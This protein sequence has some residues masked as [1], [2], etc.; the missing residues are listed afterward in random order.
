MLL[1][2]CFCSSDLTP[3]GVI[4]R[5]TETKKKPKKKTRNGKMRRSTANSIEKKREKTTTKSP[6]QIFS[7]TTRNVDR[8]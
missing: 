8:R 3:P 7:E 4:P 1:F 5:E 2:E 6:L